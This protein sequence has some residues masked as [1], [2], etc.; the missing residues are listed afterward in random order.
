VQFDVLEKG[1]PLLTCRIC[2]LRLQHALL[3]RHC[4]RLKACIGA[5]RLSSKCFFSSCGHV[6]DARLCDPIVYS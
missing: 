5:H 4:S 3:T 2:L 6:W 1:V